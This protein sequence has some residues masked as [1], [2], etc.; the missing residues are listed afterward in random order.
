MKRV[1]LFTLL[2]VV[3]A[4]LLTGCGGGGSTNQVSTG[5]GQVVLQTGDAVN[6]QIAK[7]EL[8]ISSITLTGVSPTATTAN[9][10]AKPAE[11]EFSHQA[12][13]FE[14][15]TLANLPPGTYNG[16]TITVTGA[17]VVVLNAGVPTKI[18]AT[19]SSGTVTVT[20]A[21]ITV[22]STPLFLNFDLDLAASVVLN[23]TPITSA[24]VTPKFNVTSAATPPAGNEGNEDHDNGEMDDVHGSV[25][26]ISAPN[27]TVTTKTTDITFATD[28]NTRFKDGITQ[29]SDLKVG[30]IVEVDAITKSDGTKLA[31]KVEREGG[32]NGEEAEGLISALDNPLTKIT[33]VHQVDST[34]SSNSPVTVDIGVNS[35]TVYSVRTDK[36]SITAPPF[37]ATH[38]GKGQRIEADASNNVT[39]LTATKVKLREQALI[40]TVAASPA[41]TASGFTIT[42]SPTSAFG[43]LSGATSVAVTFANGATL[44]TTPVAGAT[45]R[46]R[47]LV[48]FNGG[49]YSM[50]AVR[51][52]DN[53]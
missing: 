33:I 9:L 13:T 49:V 4:L 27:F 26:S 28:A 34:G 1:Y 37:D 14:P 50:I 2:C 16:A 45:I 20:F 47:G 31:T 29:L 46:A 12:G 23:G 39:P 40:G 18:P 36:L 19:I 15:L 3:F 30:D 8:N 10:L 35:S 51:D 25:K 7:F 32:Q 21:N 52:D 22:T 5:A 42:I 53:H 24:T 41:P 11:V 44:K 43:T 6:D 38:I 17:E 48:F